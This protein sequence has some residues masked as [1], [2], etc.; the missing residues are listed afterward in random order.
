MI[1]QYLRKNGLGVKFNRQYVIYDYIV[2]FIC[3]EK[4]LIIEIDGGYHSEYEQI[5]KDE[6]RTEK[7]EAMGFKVIRFANEEIFANIEWVINKI[8]EHFIK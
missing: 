6:H 1:W 3:L 5:E 4:K 2:D 8:K 7:L